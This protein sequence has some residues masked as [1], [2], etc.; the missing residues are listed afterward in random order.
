MVPS[1]IISVYWKILHA[2]FSRV[3][4]S[5]YDKLI[6][7]DSPDILGRFALA[8]SWQVNHKTRPMLL[9]VQLVDLWN[10]HKLLCEVCTHYNHACTAIVLVWIGSTGSILHLQLNK[11]HG[12]FS[13]SYILSILLTE[14]MDTL[15]LYR[16]IVLIHDECHSICELLISSIGGVW[17]AFAR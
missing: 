16:Y 12:E 10:F 13:I 6:V 11:V 14:S 17:A 5:C 8:M 1:T 2:W 3:Y 9:A 4:G 7:T 15:V